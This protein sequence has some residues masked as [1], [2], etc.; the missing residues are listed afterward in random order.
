MV[1]HDRTEENIEFLGSELDVVASVAR[2]K[3]ETILKE[4]KK[5]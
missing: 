3:Q 5:Y 2:E 1:N 4:L